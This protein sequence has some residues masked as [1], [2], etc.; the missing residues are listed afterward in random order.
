MAGLVRPHE[1]TDPVA[2]CRYARSAGLDLA[3]ATSA[4]TGPAR[5]VR[6]STASWWDSFADYTAL[7]RLEPGARLWVPGPAR[8]TMNLFALVHAAET[9]VRVVGSPKE[10][11]HACLTPAHLDRALSKLSRET[12]VVVAGAA[13][14]TGLASR[15]AEAGLDVQHYYGAAELSFVAWVGADG[16]RAFPGVEVEA[17]PEEAGSVLWARS[18]YLCDGYFGEPGPLRRDGDGWASVGDLG[19]VTDGRIEVLGRPDAIITAAATVLVADVERAL[20]GCATRDFAVH[21]TAH[22]TLGQVVTVTL[23]DRANREPMERHARAHLPVSHRPRRWRVVDSLP[24][25]AA[26]KLDRAA[27]ER[28]DL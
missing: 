27:L 28:A 14:P 7:A 21:A 17:R 5:E 19:T 11:S 10:A 13:L 25:T 4:T 26:G 8:A 22:A 3:L 18:A 6:R 15:A 16:L 2:A 20:S 9:G 23:T 1:A 12:V 24:L